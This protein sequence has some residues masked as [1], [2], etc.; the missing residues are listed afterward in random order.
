MS[1]LTSLQLK[2]LSTTT[3]IAG[4]R[5]A[6]SLTA[7]LVTEYAPGA[8]IGWHR[9]APQYGPVVIGVSLASA[10]RMRM[11]REQR[12]PARLG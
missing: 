10:C 2:R 9:D 11:R 3:V 6:V 1:E 8:V 7:A 12:Q 4:R 5:V